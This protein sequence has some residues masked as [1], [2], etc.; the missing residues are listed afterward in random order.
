ML[1]YKITFIIWP[2]WLCE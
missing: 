1:I 2:I